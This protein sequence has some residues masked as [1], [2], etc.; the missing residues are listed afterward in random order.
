MA[1]AAMAVDH[2]RGQGQDDDDEAKTSKQNHHGTKSLSTKGNRA[3][4]GRKIFVA[5]RV[6]T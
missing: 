2:R 1:S 5:N 6:V 4:K 3:V